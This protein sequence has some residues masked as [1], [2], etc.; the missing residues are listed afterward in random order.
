[1]KL[2]WKTWTMLF[3]LV[4]I[5]VFSFADS[6][7]YWYQTSEGGETAKGFTRPEE[8]D[9]EWNPQDWV[10][11]AIKNGM[12]I[13]NSATIKGRNGWSVGLNSSSENKLIF[14]A[15]PDFYSKD[16]WLGKDADPENAHEVIDFINYVSW[17]WELEPRKTFY[18]RYKNED[19][20]K[21][22]HLDYTVRFNDPS[23]NFPLEA[24]HFNP[25]VLNTLEE[26]DKLK[27]NNKNKAVVTESKRYSS[28][29]IKNND[30]TLKV[31]TNDLV[32]EIDSLEFEGDLNIVVEPTVDIGNAGDV[33]LFLDSCSEINGSRTIGN[34]AFKEKT[35]IFYRGSDDFII[36][37]SGL[38]YASLYL[39]NAGLQTKASGGGLHEVVSIS[40]GDISLNS[41]PE[42]QNQGT[43]GT[44][45]TDRLCDSIYSL[46]SKVLVDSDGI[47]NKGIVTGGSLV[48][49][50]CAGGGNLSSFTLEYIY[51][52]K[53]HVRFNYDSTFEG[54]YIGDSITINSGSIEIKGPP[55]DVIEKPIIPQPNASNG[56]G[57]DG[58]G[59][60]LIP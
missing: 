3:T 32:L 34:D 42:E 25:T 21:F 8:D 18:K 45:G 12:L 60:W 52:P 48:D 15:Y 41:K 29:E 17:E 36:S 31:G 28:V 46:K 51:A 16:F 10:L 22:N 33:F 57:G 38:V 37:G 6:E 1:M 43:E 47:I 30:L 26:E 55:H 54:S 27:T 50:G 5:A 44:E 4:I 53:A 59:D 11:F 56:S 58:E 49:V 19:G 2:N 9:G 7:Y 20:M 14:S 40:S 35:H 23:E 39:Q 24:V 13:T